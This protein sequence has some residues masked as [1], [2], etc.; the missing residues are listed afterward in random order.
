MLF[1]M[2]N[3]GLLFRF[4]RLQLQLKAS[5][6]NSKKI[7]AKIKRIRITQS[8]LYLNLLLYAIAWMIYII[9]YSEVAKGPPYIIAIGIVCY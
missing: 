6:E 1:D 2:I 3:Y 4:A 9:T 8:I 5:E 7:V